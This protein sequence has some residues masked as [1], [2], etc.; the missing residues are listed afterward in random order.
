M[1]KIV[2]TLMIILT[3]FSCNFLVLDSDTKFYNSQLYFLLHSICKRIANFIVWI[4]SFKFLN[5]QLKTAKFSAK[6]IYNWCAIIS[7]KIP[8]F[9]LYK[10]CRSKHHICLMSESWQLWCNGE[11]LGF[12][13]W[14]WQVRILMEEISFLK[15]I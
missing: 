8:V 1:F 4:Y 11:H 6:W 5:V 10:L 12:R 3:T 9:N 7:G 2:F 13:T 15:D 14:R